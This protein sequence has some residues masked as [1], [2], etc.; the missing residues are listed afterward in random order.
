MPFRE[1]V[2]GAAYL[3]WVLHLV[4]DWRGLVREVVRVVRPAGTFLAN[5]GAYG[6][7]RAEIQARF[8][9][10]VG[11]SLDPVGL[12]WGDLDGLDAELGSLGARSRELP[13]VRDQGTDSLAE[14]LGGIAEN[15]YSWTWTVAE[16]DRRRAHA[17]LLPWARDRYGDLRAERSWVHDSRWRAYDLGAGGPSGAP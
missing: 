2:F 14:F 13:P 10:L 9:E 8:A 11:I 7:E 1:G 3:R 6:G 17:E 4:P 5:L 16:R 12:G 15:R